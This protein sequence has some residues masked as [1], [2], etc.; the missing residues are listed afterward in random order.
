MGE[1]GGGHAQG[2]RMGRNSALTQSR[3]LVPASD[4]PT[5]GSESSHGSQG[6]GFTGATSLSAVSAWLDSGSLQTEDPR[7]AGRGS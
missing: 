2:G 7:L 5:A 1:S 3:R 6:A 4:W